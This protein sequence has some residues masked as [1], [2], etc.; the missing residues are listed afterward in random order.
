M[1]SLLDRPTSI[2]N[3]SL[4]ARIQHADFFFFDGSNV[5]WFLSLEVWTED[6]HEAR[7]INILLL[8][9]FCSKSFNVVKSSANFSFFATG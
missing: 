8:D 3:T 1:R 6:W 7:S 2:S 9:V 4:V 5:T